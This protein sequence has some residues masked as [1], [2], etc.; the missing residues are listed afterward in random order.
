MEFEK[1]RGQVHGWP[2]DTEANILMA[3]VKAASS[4]FPQQ[5][6][7]LVERCKTVISHCGG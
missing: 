3:I 1:C 4:V 7:N 5:S 2:P 6:K